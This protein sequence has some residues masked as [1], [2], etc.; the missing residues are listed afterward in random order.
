MENPSYQKSVWKKIGISNTRIDEITDQCFQLRKRSK[1]KKSIL[2]KKIADQPS[3]TALEKV[4]M[5][6][7]MGEVIGGSEAISQNVLSLLNGLE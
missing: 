1:G 3:W 5:A 4:A 6:W 7:R 2:L